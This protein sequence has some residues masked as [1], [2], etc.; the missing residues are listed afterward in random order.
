[1]LEIYNKTVISLCKDAFPT[2]FR[3]HK[4]ILLVIISF[5]RIKCR[6]KF[7][8]QK[9]FAMLHLLPKRGLQCQFY[10]PKEACDVKFTTQ[11][12]LAMPILL[13]KRDLQCQL[14]Y[15]KEIYEDKPT[16]QKNMIDKF[17]F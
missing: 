5:R 7:T 10:Y 15:P 9:K 4:M 8:T 16:T 14:C 11:K 6:G 3:V 1:M 12:R 2:K 13:P 17:P